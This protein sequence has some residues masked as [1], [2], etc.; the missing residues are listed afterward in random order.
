MR[1]FSLLVI[2]I[3]LFSGITAQEKTEKIKWQANRP[4]SWNDFKAKPDYTNSY[5][6]NTNSGFSYSWTYSTASGKPVLEHEVHTNFYPGKSW[7]KDVQDKEYLLAH[8]QLHFD[9][10]ELHARKL[11]RELENYIPGRNIR[12]DLKKIYNSIEAQR[13][14]MQNKFDRETSHSANKVAEEKWRDFVSKELEKLERY[15]S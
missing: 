4:L 8:E 3:F 15:S 7:V 10:S 11:R 6:A 9:I 2:C 1:K 5:S 14:A 13:V 12:Q